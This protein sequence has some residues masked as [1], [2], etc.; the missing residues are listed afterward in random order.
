MTRYFLIFLIV[1]LLAAAGHAAEPI[2]IVRGQDFPPYHYM[3]ETGKEAGFEI[4]MI[5]T[6][7]RQ[8][9]IRVQFKQYPWSRCILLVKTGRADA[10]MNLFKTTAR[11]EFLFFSD[12]IIGYETNSFFTL[13]KARPDYDG[14]PESLKTLKIGAIRNYSYGSRYD[15]ITF[16]FYFQLETEQ[17][18]VKALLNK[19]VDV[20][21]GNKLVIMILAKETIASDR[22]K[23]LTPD[24]SRE[25]LYLGFSRVQGHQALSE[26]FSSILMQ[27]KSTKEYRSLLK[28]Y[29]VDSPE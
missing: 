22:I 14:N 15:S 18:L 4:E 21:I 13:A 1:T 2:T 19:R 23:A 17:Q 28:R 27:F 25:P 5:Q 8:M 12:N 20:I 3:D 10:M 9:G 26:R 7:A 6:V 16:P 29:G 24:V 11:E